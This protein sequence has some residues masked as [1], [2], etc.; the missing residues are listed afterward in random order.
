M[1]AFTTNSPAWRR[2]SKATFAAL[3]AGLSGISASPAALA[4]SPVP[5]SW[6]GFYVGLNAGFG[7]GELDPRYDLTNTEI[8]VDYTDRQA[9]RLG[10]F[11]A[12]GQAG[13]NRQFGNALVGIETDLQ[14]SGIA[15]QYH[16]R[17]L[18]QGNFNTSFASTGLQL[19]NMDVTQDWFGT[20]R[21]RL[22]HV[23][24]GQWLAYVTGGV[25]YAQFNAGNSGYRMSLSTPG[26]DGQVSGSAA[27]TKIGW[28][29]GAG[30][31][32]AVNSRFSVKTEYLYTQYS[33]LTSG[34][35]AAYS[36]PIFG[37]FATGTIGL[38]LVRAGVNARLGE[39]DQPAAQL[40]PSW[41]ANWN[42][43][44]AGINGGFG[45]GVF[46][47]S[48]SEAETDIAFPATVFLSNFL[49]NEHMRAGG[50]LAGA[51]VGYNRD[52]S[53]RLV[54][55]FE[56]DL[57]WSDIAAYRHNDRS[58]VNA[59]VYEHPHI[60]IRQDWF[61]TTRLRL[62][63]RAS[64]RLLAYATAGAAYARFSAGTAD[65][66]NDTETFGTTS[67]TRAATRLGWTAGAGVE[68]ALSERIGFKT[69]YLYSEFAGF[70][71]PYSTTG[72]TIVG[73]FTRQSAFDTGKLGIHTVRAG[74][75]W[76][77]GD[78]AH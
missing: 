42:G 29:A 4:A 47:P 41:Q 7:G 37:S 23:F 15:A 31:E 5:Y 63:Y 17:T 70:S 27:S 69:E 20:T 56:T 21:L 12:G 38:H 62:G 66:W 24:A 59:L 33:G 1:M 35:L 60:D 72:G 54:A 11:F 25:A 10:G 40:A 61:G 26:V 48:R 9:H 19:A 13:Y 77:L 58:S 18:L 53:D 43:F 65:V 46:R 68:Y 34:Y 64:D 6:T 22:G 67:G 2:P 44:Y 30:L 55:G 76:K 50:F 75:N 32:Y 57:Q 45:G 36:S 8:S 52:I 71:F 74:L 49:I 39:P 51:Q 16:K 78:P 73:T 28:A 14:W 3:L